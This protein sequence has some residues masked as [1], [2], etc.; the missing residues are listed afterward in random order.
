MAVIADWV[1][2]VARYSFQ[3]SHFERTRELPDGVPKNHRR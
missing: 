2:Q 1:P 3:A